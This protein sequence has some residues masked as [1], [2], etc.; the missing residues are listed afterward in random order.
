MSA[1]SRH[2][3]TYPARCDASGMSRCI[4][5]SAIKGGEWRKRNQT[6]RQVANVQY[7]LM[8]FPRPPSLNVLI[9]LT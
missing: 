2:N 3:S 6:Q 4:R 1:S 8:F 9:F 7:P 5:R